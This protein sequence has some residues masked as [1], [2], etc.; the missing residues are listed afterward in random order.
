MA[1][2][3]S[4]NE[5]SK[6][7]YAAWRLL[8]FDRGAISLLD[9]TFEGAVKSYWCAAIIL[10]LYA[11]FLLLEA[12]VGATHM[13]I[14]AN[15]AEQAGLLNALVAEAVFYTLAWWVAWP[16]IMDRVAPWL[17]RDEYYFRYVVAYNWAHSIRIGLLIVYMAMRYGGMIPDDMLVVAQLS[18]LILLCAYHWFLLRNVLEID[19]GTAIGLVAAEYAMI[20]IINKAVISTAL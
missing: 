5:A 11:M 8:R 1:V 4:V 6:G 15:L 17:G 16:L 18:L 9:N 2:S 20:V 10:P 7:V 12:G 13:G 3:I 19:G 14:F